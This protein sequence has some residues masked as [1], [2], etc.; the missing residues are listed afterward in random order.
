MEKKEKKNIV[1]LLE[2]IL[3]KFESPV[4]VS[5]GVE[6]WQKGNTILSNLYTNSQFEK[7]SPKAA[8]EKGIVFFNIIN[9]SLGAFERKVTEPLLKPMSINIKDEITKYLSQA[10]LNELID[11]EQVADLIKNGV[12]HS[13]GKYGTVILKIRPEAK[14][15]ERIQMVDFNKI[16]WDQNDYKQAPIVITSSVKLNT[17]LNNKTWATKE[18][19]EKIIKAKIDVND[20]LT[21]LTVFE[22]YGDIPKKFRTYDERDVKTEYQYHIIAIFNNEYFPLYSAKY[23]GGSPFFVLKRNPIEN[24]SAGQSIVEELIQAQVQVNESQNLLIKEL[25]NITKTVYQTTDEGLDGLDLAEIDDMT[26]IKTD[27]DTRLDIFPQRQSNFMALQNYTMSW[28]NQSKEQGG[29]T[30]AMLG[31]G[32]G[33]REPVGTRGYKVQEASDTYG[34]ES[35]NIGLF[36]EGIFKSK[37]LGVVYDYFKN[38]DKIEDLLTPEQLNSFH[39]YLS[40]IISA[41]MTDEV[42]LQ[43]G[44][45]VKQSEL[46]PIVLQRLTDGKIQIEHKDYMIDKKTFIDKARVNIVGQMQNKRGEL[47][48]LQLMAQYLIQN[49]QLQESM[50]VKVEDVIKK[51]V[52][53]SD[54]SA[55]AELSTSMAQTKINNNP[56]MSQ[57]T[58]VNDPL[59]NQRQ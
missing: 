19:E 13:Y 8:K 30:N 26:V 40:K 1:K 17:I 33:T 49:P 46:Q 20:I 54:G 57:P 59:Q 12:V 51:L 11:D 6:F 2:S 32:E 5:Q 48:A 31:V 38:S 14:K 27:R 18:L 25:R 34:F 52:E 4:K 53:L 23:K 21:R 10:G 45:D 47:T 29:A 55:V 7:L 50:G 9:Q 16:I 22:M 42:A 39:I 56:A 37:L 36:F 43:D 3:D 28:L 15:G 24:R 35:I 44:P 58:Q 41:R